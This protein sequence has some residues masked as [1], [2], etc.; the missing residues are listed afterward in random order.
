[1]TEA[2]PVEVEGI[3]GRKAFIDNLI[4]EEGVVEETISR[5]DKLEDLV[6]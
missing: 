6:R 3:L 1:M 4:F 2:Y 5:Y